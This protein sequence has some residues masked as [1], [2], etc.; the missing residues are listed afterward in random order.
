MVARGVPQIEVTFD[1]DA[2]GIVH[3]SAK[4]LGTG[5]EQKIRI[6]SSSG[7]GEEEI[8]KMVREA[9]EH[10]AEDKR[11]RDVVDARNE[12][13]ALAYAAEKALRENA[14][15][16]PAVRGRV[17][18]AV[19]SVR[20]AMQSDDLNAI[21]GAKSVL[22]KAVHEMSAGTISREMI[23]DF[24]LFIKTDQQ[25]RRRYVSHIYDGAFRR[26]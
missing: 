5:K 18:S 20:T 1:I 17:E 19:N 21:R 2:N 14:N 23:R 26:M 11:M 8:R 3:V 16:A 6:E 24:L 22:K 4:D 7:L 10:S 15:V 12:A 9:E 13:D 25:S